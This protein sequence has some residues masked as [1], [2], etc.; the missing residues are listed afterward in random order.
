LVSRRFGT[1][2]QILWPWSQDRLDFGL[3]FEGYQVSS[4]VSLK[5]LD[6]CLK[7]S[8]APVI[9]WQGS[10]H[11]RLQ[12]LEYKLISINGNFRNVQLAVRPLEKHRGLSLFFAMCLYM[13][14]C[15]PT[16][17]ANY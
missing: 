10:I 8:H 14:Y 15:D 3:G 12:G 5:S 7:S 4:T 6:A 16:S 2:C 17:H 11:E 1:R 13:H 9:K